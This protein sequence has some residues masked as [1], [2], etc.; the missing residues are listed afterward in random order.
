MMANTDFSQPTPLTFPPYT[1]IFPSTSTATRTLVYYAPETTSAMTV[2]IAT[3]VIA[4][5][6]TSTATSMMASP[7]LQPN[8]AH[9]RDGKS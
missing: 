1:W 7:T 5:I 3:S 6:A 8:Y 4:P 2:P 9:T